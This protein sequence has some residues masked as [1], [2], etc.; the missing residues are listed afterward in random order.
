MF[1]L[2]VQNE[3]IYFKSNTHSP[4]LLYVSKLFHRG[5]WNS[6]GAVHSDFIAVHRS[7][8]ADASFLQQL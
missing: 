2:E 1:H 4:V 8:S 6:N 5:L 7:K 3:L